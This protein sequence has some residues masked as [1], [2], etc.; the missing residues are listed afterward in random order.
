MKLSAENVTN[1][2]VVCPFPRMMWQ[3]LPGGMP[4]YAVK[5]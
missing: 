2:F 1:I 3:S 5:A 4:Y